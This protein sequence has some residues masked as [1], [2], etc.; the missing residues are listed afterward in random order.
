M[1]TNRIRAKKFFITVLNERLPDNLQFN[2]VNI[3][4]DNLNLLIN[5]YAKLFTIKDIGEFDI[6]RENNSGILSFFPIDDRPNDYTYAY[7]SFSYI[8][9][10]LF[11]EFMNEFFG[12]LI[13]IISINEKRTSNFSKLIE[14]PFDFSSSKIQLQI[15]IGDNY[16]YDEINLTHN[17][18]NPSIEGQSLSNVRYGSI[19]SGPLSKLNSVGLGTYFPY[20]EDNKVYI[21]FIPSVSIVDEINFNASLVSIANTNFS[22]EGSKNLGNIVIKSKKTFIPKSEIL[23]GIPT[24]IVVGLHELQYQASYY[25]AQCTDLNNNHTQLSEIIVINNRTQSYLIEYASTFTKDRIGTFSTLKTLD[26]ELLFTPIKN[27]DIEVVLFQ[28]K[29]SSFIN[30]S[31]SN[32]LESDNF[33]IESGLSR[34]GIDGDFLTSFD[35]THEQ[36]P[37]FERLFDGGNSKIVNLDDNTILLPKHFFVTG[38]KVKYISDEFDENNNNNSIRIESVEIPGIGITDRL[39][40]D[41]YVIKVDSTKI[42]FAKSAEDALKIL[43]EPLNFTSL[44]SEGVHKIV[45]TQQNTKSLISIDN[46]IQSPIRWSDTVTTLLEDIDFE[47]SLIIVN[48]EKLFSFNDIIKIDD[49]LMR[50]SSVGIG[51]TNSLAIIRNILGTDTQQHFSGASVRK[52]KGNYNISGNKIYFASPPYGL[53]PNPSQNDPF[54]EKD[55]FGIQTKSSFD[56]RIFLRS[57][58]P[59]STN[60]T[61]TGNFIFDDLNR[62]FNGFEN[63]FTLKNND[64]S[65]LDIS[66]NNA[67]VL[68]NSIYQSPKPKVTE[69]SNVKGFYELKESEGE[70][71]I[72]FTGEPIQNLSDINTSNIPYGGVIVSVGSTD[73]FGYQPLVSAGGTSVVSIAG[74]ISQISIGNSGSGYRVGI[75]TQ[76]NV[77]VKKYSSGLPN[78]EIVGIAS[79]VDGNVIDVKITNPGSGYTSTNPPEVIFDSPIGYTNIPLVYSNQSQS[80]IGTKANVDIVVGESG[81]IIDFNI[82]NFGYGYKIGDILT[83][84]IDSN[85]G[86]LTTNSNLFSEFQIFVDQTYNVDFSGWSMGEFDVL[87]NLDSKFNGSNKNFQI[88]FEGRPISISKKKSSPIELEYVLLVFIND[89]LQIPFKDYTFTGSI[90]RFNSS[91]RGPSTNPPFGG[92]T[93][94]II[95]YKGTPEIDVIDTEILDSPKIGD[96]LTIKSN[97]KNLS[98]KSRII[99]FIP[100]IDT[101]DTNK[102]SDIGISED[103]NLLRP[104]EWCKQTDDLYIFGKEITKDRKIYNPYI[105]PVSYLIKNLNENDSQI[106]VDSAKLFFD[107]SKENVSQ[108]ESNIIQIISNSEN[109]GEFETITNIQGIEGDFGLIVGIDSTSIPGIANTCLVFDFFVPPDSYLRNVDLNSGISTDGISGIQT[110][111]RFV[112]SGTNKGTPNITFDIDGNT[113]GIGNA[114]LDNIYE[115]IHFYVD[116]VNIVG[117]G[118]TFV[119]K[120]ISPVNTYGGINQFGE[121]SGK[122]SWG[123]IIS[124]FR[125]SPK[126]FNIN[127]SSLS[128]IKANPII[129]RKKSLKNNLYLS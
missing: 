95:F 117:V 28:I 69:L 85:V 66:E 24:A 77:G 57:G 31:G 27:S 121:F 94:K 35:L 39:P 96:Y 88:S 116:T 112:V 64:E 72:K 1:S 106:F 6:V 2:I 99:E 73:G 51:T 108:N 129:R 98:Q 84:P 21:D 81:N 100:S 91:P 58:I 48:N 118:V 25:I 128:E 20:I 43:P 123:K 42:K 86:I 105:N 63:E 126:T 75:Q 49:E 70:T 40:T 17:A 52:I 54:D 120:V 74:T 113:I 26:T 122:Y 78:I 107:Y 127:P 8:Q 76:V 37:I 83:V 115:C 61:Y 125:S 65:I 67:I 11:E 47:D 71:K 124:P 10:K 29:I 104:V 19:F 97:I 16:Q 119:T 55:Y 93:S 109:V 53:E 4:N 9:E 62:Q 101:A 92:D 36:V 102:Y 114:F 30:V 79:I 38:E 5:Q 82:N 111:Y 41:L 13:K 87:D 7:C 46:V 68:L 32:S 3:L 15:K 89:V 14:I 23:N 12:D 45:A 80:G 56:G 22:T 103:I 18:N 44:G 34:S 59:L 110:G 60:K 50:V 33:I 90:I